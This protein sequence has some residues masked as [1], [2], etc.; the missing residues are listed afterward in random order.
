MRKL[1]GSKDISEI[2][3]LEKQRTRKM[4]FDF[5]D[6][7]KPVDHKNFSVNGRS[8]YKLYDADAVD[9]IRQ[10]VIY[11]ELGLSPREIKAIFSNPA[12]DPNRVLNEQLSLLHEKRERINRQIEAV[13]RLRVFGVKNGIVEL[14]MPK[15]AIQGSVDLRQSEISRRVSAMAEKYIAD[16][17]GLEEFILQLEPVWDAYAKLE[18]SLCESGEGQELIGKI[19]AVLKQTFGFF[20]YVC[21]FG[22]ALS[23]H[24]DGTFWREVNDELES[25]LSAQKYHALYRWWLNDINAFDAE[26]RDLARQHNC[27]GLAF[28]DKRSVSFVADVRVLVQEHFALKTDEDYK[29]LF[30]TMNLKPYKSGDG[31]A[32]YT[33]NALK[34]GTE[35]RL[36]LSEK[37]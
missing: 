8:A 11:K 25:P 18:D 9:V 15:G 23:A 7:V 12:Y 14:I 17:A 2:V 16:D 34:F 4:L 19:A 32:R 6:I 31:Y 30:S 24:G 10:I 21:L 35:S 33:L 26:L 5:E 3:G 13:E 29:L 28:Q 36:E 37:G 22:M 1:Y 27:I 20:G